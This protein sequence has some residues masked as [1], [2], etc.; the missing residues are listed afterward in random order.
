MLGNRRN[1]LKWWCKMV[2]CHGKKSPLNKSKFLQVSQEPRFFYYQ[3][4]FGAT[5]FF[6]TSMCV[7]LQ[8]FRDRM[9]IFFSLLISQ[10]AIVYKIEDAVKLIHLVFDR[11]SWQSNLG[12]T[13]HQMP[14]F[15]FT[16]KDVDAPSSFRQKNPWTGKLNWECFTCPSSMAELEGV[17]HGV[18]VGWSW[19]IF[20]CKANLANP[21]AKR[22]FQAFEKP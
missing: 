7:C 17:F 13:N 16:K 1:S 8:F 21:M 10:V 4:F 22:I 2:I 15:F 12:Y 9:F 18:V 11:R 19:M 6:W 5:G 3:N 20:F 14:Q